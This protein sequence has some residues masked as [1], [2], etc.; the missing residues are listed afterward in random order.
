ML[1]RKI[2]RCLVQEVNKRG[3]SAFKFVSPGCDGVPDRLILFPGGKIAF[4]EVKAPGIKLRP[5]QMKR[6]KDFVELGQKVYEVDNAEMIGGVLDE[7]QS[8]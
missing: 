5:L 7:I 8:T 4:I 6:V 3:G 1:E 2:E